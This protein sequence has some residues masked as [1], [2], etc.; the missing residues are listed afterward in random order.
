MYVCMYVC[1]YMIYMNAHICIHTYIDIC[2]Y[3]NIYM[4]LGYLFGFYG[5]ST[6][7]GYF[8]TIS[9][10]CIYSHISKQINSR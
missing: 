9:V 3:R 4:Y 6:I 10:I 7:V 5:I 2:K 8:T 1:M